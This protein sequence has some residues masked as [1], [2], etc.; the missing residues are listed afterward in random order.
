VPESRSCRRALKLGKG[1]DPVSESNRPLRLEDVLVIDVDVHAHDTP[2]ELAPYAD[3]DWRPVLENL[4]DAPRRYLDL[5]GYSPFNAMYGPKLPG[6][7]PSMPR[8]GCRREIVWNAQQMRKELD[9][10]SIDIGVIFPDHHLRVGSL[11]NAR[12]A[13]ALARAYHRWLKEKWLQDENGLYGVIIA[14]PQ[15]PEQAARE[16]DRW[17]SDDRFAGVY[18]PGCEV[19]PLWGHE[20]YNPIY[21]AAQRHNLPVFFHSVAGVSS[22][23]PFNVE[24]FTTQICAHTASHVFAMMATLLS[25]MEAG[26]PVRFPELRICFCESGLS[27]VPFLRMRLDKEYNEYRYLWPHFHDRPSKWINKF[28]FATQ[29]LE[30]PENDQDLTDLIRIYH[31]E[32]T[33]VFASD[34]PHHDFDQPRA[35]FDLRVSEEMKRKVMGLNALQLMPKIKVPI[36]YQMNS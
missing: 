8:G 15:D 23:F 19:Y 21:E 35:F 7:I 12:Y 6:A 5:P 24:G 33:T 11:P 29:P 30:E 14:I 32:S 2:E 1:V 36:R 22:A 9:E 26:I 31:G 34:W 27:W 13:G 17:A 4:R 25:L 18:L 10:F 28:Y 3:A 16:I 20:K